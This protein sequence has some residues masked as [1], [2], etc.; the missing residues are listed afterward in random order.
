MIERLVRGL[1]TVGLEADWRDIADSLWLARA[2]AEKPVSLGGRGE[3][4]LD[5]GDA[6]DER[7]P[8][9][10]PP[11]ETK[12]AD[13]TL[14]EGLPFGTPTVG[15]TRGAS[16]ADGGRPLD[17]RRSPATALPNRLEIGRALRPLMA[18][19][20][21]ATNCVFDTDATIHR[22]CDT[23][24]LVPVR[25]PVR[26]RWFSEVAIVTDGAPTMAVWLE[27]VASLADLLEHHGAFARVSRWTLAGDDEHV[28]VVAS[29]GLRH[30]PQA[31]IDQ[32]ARRLTL[33]VSDCVG[34]VWRG[35]GVWAA[36][37]EWGR[38]APVALVQTLPSRL[39]PATALG[40]VELLLASGCPGAPNRQLDL[41]LPWWWDDEVPQ[42]V[43]PVVTLDE[44]HLLPWARMLM[45]G[46]ERRVAGVAAGT[47]D[48]VGLDQVPLALDPATR[49]AAFRSTVSEEGSRLA[50]LLS[51]VVVTLPVARLLV[52]QL[53]EGGRQIHIAEVLASG[54][55]ELQ[56]GD[57]ADEPAYRFAAG[58]REI[59]QESLTT[60]ATLDVWRTVAPHLEAATGHR[61]PFSTLFGPRSGLDQETPGVV[62]GEIAGALIKR[63]GLAA[64][65]PAELDTPL[66]SPAPSSAPVNRLPFGQLDAGDF[67]RFCVSLVTVQEPV[68]TAS[69]SE[70][71]VDFVTMR[72]DVP[73]A[74]YQCR[75]IATVR[76]SD[77]REAVDRF[78]RQSVRAPR[79]VLCTS[80]TV[81]VDARAQIRVESARLEPNLT[82]EV[83]DGAALSAAAAA[84]PML[85]AEF[86]G[87]EIDVLVIVNGAASAHI[88]ETVFD[89]DV[90]IADRAG[91]RLP[92]AVLHSAGGPL[93]ICVA[94]VEDV[95]RVQARACFVIEAAMGL[96]GAVSVNDVVIPDQFVVRPAAQRGIESFRPDAR[97]QRELST[98]RE[99]L[100]ES[101]RMELLLAAQQLEVEL[102]GDPEIRRG[103]ILVG[104]AVEAVPPSE[105]V[106][107][108]GA[109]IL[110][111]HNSTV[112]ILTAAGYAEWAVFLGI[113]DLQFAEDVDGALDSALL[114]AAVALRN[115]LQHH[116]LVSRRTGGNPPSGQRFPTSQDLGDA[117]PH[118]DSDANLGG[119]AALARDRGDPNEAEMLYRRAADLSEGANDPGAAVT[120]REPRL[121]R[122]LARFI[123]NGALRTRERAYV[124]RAAET[125][126]FHRLSAG[127]WVFLIGP[128]RCGKSSAMIRMQ[129]RLKDSGYR[130][131]FID[132]QSYGGVDAE[133]GSF[134]EWFAEKLAAELRT[135]FVRPPK[136]RRNQ[137]ELW[138][139]AVVAPELRKTAIL[140]DEVGGMPDHFRRP[141]FAQLRAFFNSRANSGSSG[142]DV[143]DHVSFAFAGTLLPDRLIDDHSSP[144]N[145][146]LVIDRWDLTREEVAELASFGLGGDAQHYAQRTFAQTLGQP[147]YAQYLLA[148][149]QLAGNDPAA[150]SAVFDSALEQLRQRAGGHLEDLARWVENDDELRALVRGILQGNLSFQP[151]SRLHRDAIIT[152]VAR[153]DAGRLVTPNPIDASALARFAD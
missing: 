152:G 78:L 13:S 67:E 30:D 117:E 34:P 132:L 18:K 150:R 23:G 120:A 65:P 72:D 37:R 68:V 47:Q 11:P 110:A 121:G 118:T 135:D 136:R 147:Y 25:S 102:R 66:D 92:T 101:F 14:R 111:A 51:A 45:G 79:L 100:G 139:R 85:A 70:S 97:L 84:H 151:S 125:E 31:L 145:V 89:T 26:E 40:D 32:S 77:V 69:P 9:H 113:S 88:L 16:T 33:V 52:S 71:G 38:F 99:R 134:L 12:R 27:T 48:R 137:L 76:A 131:A 82:L 75:H 108:D 62:A 74:A 22:Y 1:R 21:S 153:Y 91:R 130:C 119:L 53:I 5:A 106:T 142:S 19:R 73:L 115:F 50:V 49:V 59:L 98:F 109:P 140:I 81:A 28:V 10:P 20:R 96:V 42:D 39:W 80:G 29:S 128:R 83:L 36:L 114:T 4:G 57:T 8:S 148:A 41:Q 87:S 35:D 143:A 105:R 90:S 55:V 124:V 24:V 146:A 46:R 127:E 61:S 129:S 123:P 133:Y 112:Q 86:F 126:A 60:T 107:A 94:E 54:L 56:S 2:S 122:D 149:V 93:K 44:R 116:Y 138:L 17:L 43:V 63:L 141:F 103:A 6:A 95:G 15:L 58:V 144:F 104:T 7:E 3:N 64:L